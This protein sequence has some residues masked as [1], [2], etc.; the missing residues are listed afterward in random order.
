MERTNLNVKV[1]KK[2]DCNYLVVAIFEDG[3][4]LYYQTIAD[5]E[6]QAKTNM[7]LWLYNHNP[8]E[9][10]IAKVEVESI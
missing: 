9:K 3:S 10:Y 6:E 7:R 2:S 4:F 8:L 5:N 1:T